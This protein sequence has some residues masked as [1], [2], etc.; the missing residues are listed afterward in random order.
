MP[1]TKQSLL[2]NLSKE[3]MRKAAGNL[4]GKNY[5]KTPKYKL[6][7]ILNDFPTKKIIKALKD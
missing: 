4:T 5:D 1:T 7:K 6:I 3:K 2:E